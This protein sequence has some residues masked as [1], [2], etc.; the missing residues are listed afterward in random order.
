MNANRIVTESFIAKE[1]IA[2]DPGKS[3]GGIVVYKGDNIYETLAIK[4][5]YEKGINTDA[6]LVDWFKRQ[7]EICK[8]PLVVIEKINTYSSDFENRGKMMR[9]Q[10]LIKHY[11]SLLTAIKSAKLQ[12]IEVM[13]ISWQKYMDIYEKGE[14]YKVRKDRYKDIAQDWFVGQKVVG[15]NADAF[16]LI[17]FIRKKLRY[18]PRWIHNKLK[19][20]VKSDKSLF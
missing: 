10:S 13:P 14:D 7:K 4:K 5:F 1:L 18:E 3:N 6:E 12:L 20:C 8:L 9:M 2:I 16:L 17:E 19:Q 15:W 11:A